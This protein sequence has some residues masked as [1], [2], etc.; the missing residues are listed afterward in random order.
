MNQKPELTETEKA[1]F[2]AFEEALIYRHER[3]LTKEND[4]KTN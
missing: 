3:I 4:E 1:A 2:D